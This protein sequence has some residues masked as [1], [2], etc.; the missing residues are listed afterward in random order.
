MPK[1]D[2]RNDRAAKNGLISSHRWP[3]A[4]TAAPLFYD[5]GEQ[6]ELI[7]KFL[8]SNVLAVDIFALRRESIGEIIAPLSA[9]DNR[10]AL[11]PGEEIV[12]EVVASNRNA[13]HSFPPEVRDLYEAWVELEATDDSGKTIFHSG[14]IKP[15]GM[16][17]ETAHVYKTILLDDS[18][19]VITR[20][21][22]WTTNIKA[23]DN[24]ILPGRSD[25][26]RFRFR[27]PDNGPERA[28]G[29]KLRARINY[30]RFN[31]EYT[32][33]VLMMRNS[34]L[35]LPVVEMAQSEVGISDVVTGAAR[36]K[37]RIGDGIIVPSSQGGSKSALARRWNDYGIGLLEQAQYG[38]AS[39]AFRRA[40]EIDPSDP[41][42]L[43][44]AAI[45]ELR[46]ERYGPEREQLSK[47]AVLLDRALKIKPMHARSRYW[48]AV[49]LRGYGKL[50][51][52][53]ETFE[54]L[55]KEY[56]RDRE[57]Q[58]QLGQTLYSLGRLDEAR[59]A[60]EAV[61]AIEPQDAGAYQLLAPIYLSQ[62]RQSQSDSARALYLQWRDDPLA[63]PIAARFFAAHPE[64]AEERVTS[65]THGLDS[66]RRVTLTGA[67]ANPVK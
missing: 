30:R 3:G 66:A 11:K 21:Q 7:R 64:W 15:D 37:A 33:Y 45:A 8:E 24:T 53:A 17:D 19:R 55:A 47:A 58:R 13:A 29:I 4:N 34:K 59:I 28:V 18:A 52:A 50:A 32:N 44:N 38:P 6:A 16:L 48:R 63:N 31:Q 54:V 46:T 60:L 35:D 40:S 51:A 22:I 25:V 43:V 42:L 67:L 14:Y 26:A 41:N 57:V 9:T 12:A 62:G 49:V 5:Q 65:H 39:E 1:I 10:I 56:P 20:H 36:Q 27:V 61:V 23:Y 2:S